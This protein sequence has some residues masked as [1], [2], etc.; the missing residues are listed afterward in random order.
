MNKKN[1]LLD[2]DYTLFN[3]D[4]FRDLTYPKLLKL[5][6]YEDIPFN[7]EKVKMIEHKLISMGGYEP[8]VFARLLAEALEVESDSVEMERLFYDASLYEQCLYPDV[9]KVIDTLSKKKDITLGIVSKGEKTFQER[10]IAK[11]RHYFLDRNVHISLNKL[12]KIREIENQYAGEEM[13]V[14]DDSAIFLHALKVTQPSIFTLFVVREKRYEERD[15]PEYFHPD[16]TIA[17]LDE[18]LRIVDK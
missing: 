14:A 4:K 8:V 15:V 16:A 12:D 17:T 11:I 9:E 5:L 1:I 18:I 7:H 6:Q 2:I 3:T 13:F 10:K